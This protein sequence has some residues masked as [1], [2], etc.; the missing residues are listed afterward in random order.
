MHFEPQIWKQS[1]QAF[2]PVTQCPGAC[3]L[4]AE[5]MRAAKPMLDGGSDT[6]KSVLVVALVEPL[7][8]RSDVPSYNH[9]VH[10]HLTIGPPS[11]YSI[12][13]PLSRPASSATPSGTRQIAGV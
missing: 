4:T 8:H 2:K 9:M 6:R 5:A 12:C 3:A 7:K 13:V 11:L 10:K 1:K